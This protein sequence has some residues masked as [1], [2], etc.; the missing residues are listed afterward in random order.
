MVVLHFKFSDCL[1]WQMRDCFC[2]CLTVVHTV[3]MGHEPWL[4][5]VVPQV[6]EC[7]GGVRSAEISMSGAVRGSDV[8]QSELDLVR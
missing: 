2:E 3:L 5:G 1:S 8:G 6:A 4:V 7:Q